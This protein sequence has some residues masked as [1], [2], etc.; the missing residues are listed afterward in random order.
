M[1]QDQSMFD[2]EYLELIIGSLFHDIGK[3]WQR[4]EKDNKDL[5]R[6][7][8]AEF[9]LR[10][11]GMPEHQFWS[12]YFLKNI[13]NED[14]AA[15]RAKNHHNPDDPFDY[16][17]AI[18]DKLS[19]EEREDREGSER[20][21]PS[22]EPL[23]SIFSQ[24]RGIREEASEPSIYYQ[25]LVGDELNLETLFPKEKKE[26]A[27][28]QKTYK[29]LWKDFENTIKE[30]NLS[31]SY[32][33]K[34]TRL[35]HFL[36]VFTTSI[37]SPAYYSVADISLFDH[38]KTTAAIAAC[39][40]QHSRRKGM[41][42]FKK[43]HY[44][45]V[46]KYKKQ[47]CNFSEMLNNEALTLL[48]GDISGIQG[49]IYDISSK[50]A[51]KSLKG[52]SLYLSLLP[53]IISKYI[54]RKLS[55]PYTNILFCKGGHFY[56]LLPLLDEEEINELQRK[57]NE[58]LFNA[59]KGTFSLVIAGVA[60]N[61]NDFSGDTLGKKWSEVFGNLQPKKKTKFKEIMMEKPNEFFGP[62]EF[63]EKLC[64]VCRSREITNLE[65][66]KCSFCE[67]FEECGEKVIK[68][69]ILR[70]RIISETPLPTSPNVTDVFK[71]FGFD[72]DFRETPEVPAVN[73]AVNERSF[74]KNGCDGF[75][76]LPNHTPLE[77]GDIL[78]FDHL[79]DKASGKKRWT[80][81]RG[82]VDN[83]GLIFGKGL[84]NRSISRVAS[85]SR[86]FSLYFTFW[87]N[88]ICKQDR[89]KDKTYVIYAGGDDF[90]IVG[91]WDVM[92]GLA[93]SINEDFRRFTCQNDHITLSSANFI[94]PSQKYP[95][96]KAAE[97][98]GIEL[99]EKAKLEDKNSIAFLGKAFTW[100]DFEKVYELKE[101]I[102]ELVKNQKVSNALIQAIYS[103]FAEFEGFKRGE[104]PINRV[105][106]LIYSLSRLAR[107]HRV[108]NEMARIEKRLILSNYNLEIGGLYAARWAELEI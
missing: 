108:E 30:T 89:F 60:L 28:N 99:D 51:A 11:I 54:V 101:A 67:S 34:L 14:D 68:K 81:L 22:M 93:M 10:G 9:G 33:K 31:V 55:L 50:G 4:A 1:H 44:A 71:A 102:I 70:E 56:L 61:F 36:E 25:P 82:D 20:A 64:K 80:V 15:K 8:N 42:D 26:D 69:N 19:G 90:F 13:L 79:S 45:L 29:T 18:A 49:F 57:I 76:Y 83:L 100:D 104:Y 77:N 86:N 24:I 107:R 105:W 74:W 96:Y 72:L 43:I 91:S 78:D 35:Y 5:I 21:D 16:L 75:V 98:C 40:Y 97:I 62:F 63:P 59:H 46:A 94:V 41:I 103:G 87:L 85:L 27:F 88:E 7:I 92:P 95:L 52:R 23:I 38:S 84:E 6:N 58:I 39:L 37:P 2:T 65:E 3:F 66:E 17:I 73:Y 106:R 48:A 47:P 53:E 32:D 12:A